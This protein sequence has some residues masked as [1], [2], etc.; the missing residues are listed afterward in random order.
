MIGVT[1]FFVIVGIVGVL[2]F[3][4]DMH[5]QKKIEQNF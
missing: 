5:N 3:I 2:Y 4:Y 1:I